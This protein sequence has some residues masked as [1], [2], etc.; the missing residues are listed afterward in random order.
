MLE[1]VILAQCIPCNDELSS[2]LILFNIF[3]VKVIKY[4]NEKCKL[5]S[6]YKKKKF[7]KN[8]LNDISR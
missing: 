6:F 4:N 7:N 1:I 3:L 8:K 2:N 5:N